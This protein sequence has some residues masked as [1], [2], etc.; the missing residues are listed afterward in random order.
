MNLKTWAL[1]LAAV[2]GLGLTAP[3]ADA[4]YLFHMRKDLDIL[5]KKTPKKIVGKQIVVTD[6]MSVIWPETVETLKAY[7][8]DKRKNEVE[9]EEHVLFATT[10]FRCAIPKDKMGTHLSSIWNDAKKGYG[11]VTKQI[12]EVNRKAASDPKGGARLS[13]A[14]AA[15]ERRKLYWELYRVWSNK[16]IVTIYGTVKRADF[17]GPVDGAASGSGV[18]TE[19]ITIVVDKVEKPRKRWYKTLDE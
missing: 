16:P 9:S 10:Y 18:A 13:A 6:E 7:Q 2:V 19:A 12:E 4:I 17:W 11:D 5:L 8:G 1:G 3:Q 14:E 15:K